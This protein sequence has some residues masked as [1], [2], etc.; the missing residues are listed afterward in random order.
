MSM[1]TVEGSDQR[2]ITLSP[3]VLM[4]LFAATLFLSA[5]L[6]FAVQ[7]MFAKMAL[8]HLGGSPS[9]WAVSMCFFQAALLAGYGYAHVLNRYASLP[10]AV[11]C[12]GALLAAAFLA[13]PIA[14]PARLGEPPA[15]DAYLWLTSVLALGVGLPFLAVSASAPLL[16]AWFAKS[17]HPAARDPYFLYGASNVGSLLVLLAYPIAIEPMMGVA[18]QSRVWGSLFPLLAAAVLA[19]GAATIVARK[20]LALQEDDQMDRSTPAPVTWAQVGIWVLLAAIPSGLMVAVTTYMTTDIASAPFLW[21]VPLALFL[22]TFILVFRETVWRHF[23]HLAYVLPVLVMLPF[24][25]ST[26]KILLALASFFVA[27]LLCHRELFLRRPDRRQLTAFYLWMSFGGVIGGVFAA[28]LAPKLFTSTI[29]YQL[30]M[31]AALFC[32][33]GPLFRSAAQLDVKRLAGISCLALACLCL[34]GL[35]ADVGGPRVHSYAVIAIVVAIGVFFLVISGWPEQ[36][37]AFMAALGIVLLIMPEGYTAIRAE[38]SFFGTVRVL[39]SANGVQRLM[40]HGT[41]LHGTRRL[42]TADGVPVTRPEPAAYYHPTG[43]MARAF[44]VVRT[45]KA[46]GSDQPANILAGVV[47]LGTGSLACYARPGDAFRFYEIDPAVV[48]LAADPKYFDFLSTC[49]PTAPIIVG[50]ARLTV[51]KEPDDLFDYLVIDAFSSDS[52]PTHLL[53]VEALKMYLSKVTDNGVIALHVSNKF[54]DLVGAVSSTLAEVPG[55]HGVYVRSKG[56]LLTSDASA[57]QVVFVTRNSRTIDA[58]LAWP[59]AGGLP[60]IEARAWTDD[61]S[62]VA[63]AVL[64]NFRQ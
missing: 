23:D 21:V 55:A 32:V 12:H 59:D 49:T 46:A 33:P 41:T 14:L 24:V 31:I 11:A 3:P 57:S 7:P 8:P 20:Q 39:E 61:Y 54:M 5:L 58:F 26:G 19:C 37:F 43:A 25:V 62:N 42:K 15:G 1:T 60:R 29:E 13:L 47:G 34:A 6:L 17:G 45:A 10:V 64:R 22:A 63:E 28:L 51:G 38:R 27:A 50:D 18:A 53:T 4:G 48:K 36:R 44:D 40:L 16:Q 9:V 2:A 52:V 56:S 30:L 35:A